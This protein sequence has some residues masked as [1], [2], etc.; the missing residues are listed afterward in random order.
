MRGNMELKDKVVIVAGGSGALGGAIAREL[1]GRG[2]H[3]VLAGR[4]RARLD[5]AASSFDSAVGVQ[6]DIRSPGSVEAPLDV[7]TKRFGRI[8]GIVN[9]AGVVAFGPVEGY[10]EEVIDEMISTNLLGP[11]HMLARAAPLVN[12]FI[13]NITGVVAE[14]A[15]PNMGPYVASKTGLSAFGRVLGRELRKKGVLVVDARPPHTETGLAGRAIHGQ[16]PEMGEGLDPAHVA[17]IIVEKGLEEE[18]ADL[19]SEAFKTD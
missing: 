13:I 18:I 19:G 8:D 15:F 1:D 7:A 2:S 3:L 4:D 5:E 17:R 14:R 16:A 10:P 6:F 12:D 9:A 11:M